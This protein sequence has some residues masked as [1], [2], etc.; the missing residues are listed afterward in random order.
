MDTPYKPTDLIEAKKYCGAKLKSPRTGTCK[1]KPMLNSRCRYHGGTTPKG[2]LHPSFR[3]GRYSKYLPGELGD[4]FELARNDAELISLNEEI[5]LVDTHLTE[6]IE[7]IYAGESKDFWKILK[8]KFFRLEDSINQVLDKSDE[9]NSQELLA[10]TETFGDTLHAGAKVFQVFEQIQP[11]I[12]MRRKLVE[13]EAKR[14]KDLDQNITVDKAMAIIR[15]LSDI[16]NRNVTDTKQR[17]AIS[18]ELAKIVA[19]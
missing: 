9:S 15:T 3:T 17:L 8:H 7:K 6:R 16:V 19:D 18:E 12:E 10:L 4:R 13:S 5:A 1:G 14:R 11:M 2:L